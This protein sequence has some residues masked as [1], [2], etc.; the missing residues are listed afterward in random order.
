M[1]LQSLKMALSSIGSSKMRSFLTMLGIIIGVTALV[2]M[3]SLVNGATDAVTSEVS[4]LGNDMIIASITDD[5]GKPL[6]LEDLESIQAMD[7][8][9]QVAPSGMMNATAKYGYDD[10]AVSLYGTTAAYL[11]IRGLEL[12]Y[13]RF[14]KTT[15]VDNGSYVAVLSNDAATE[16]FNSA[17]V[18][19]E[20]LIIAGRSFKVVG[21]LADES[22][23]M[24]GM[25]A[26]LSVYVPFS[27]ESRM[28]GQPYVTSVYASSA[29][30]GNT[31]VAEEA[32]NNF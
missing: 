16:L 15:D 23:L 19:G 21:V 9:Y 5:K 4:A 11:D 13:G 18:V 30:P 27:V 31:D 2:V 29:D 3:V 20:T 10:A 22:S 8:I 25:I 14:I 24:A 6:R 7:A 1:I 28:A 17:D 26:N 32:M 12:E